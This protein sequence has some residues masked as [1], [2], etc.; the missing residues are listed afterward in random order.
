[1][2]SLG[3]EGVGCCW[4]RDGVGERVLERSS[5]TLGLRASFPVNT[6]DITRCDLY[7]REEGF[8]MAHDKADTRLW[9]IVR[10][11]PRLVRSRSICH[12]ST[13]L[14]IAD[15]LPKNMC[16]KNRRIGGIIYCSKTN[17]VPSVKDAMPRQRIARSSSDKYTKQRDTIT[18]L[19]PIP[20]Q[21]PRVRS[22]RSP[23]HHNNMT[24]DYSTVA[25]LTVSC[26]HGD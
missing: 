10:G 2:A 9:I 15:Q 14:S 6:V 25:K 23:R 12:G 17:P 8:T 24:G 18:C 16:G 26:T 13:V 7:R 21:S 22:N 3:R 19:M 20:T 5:W 4:S 11:V 1:M